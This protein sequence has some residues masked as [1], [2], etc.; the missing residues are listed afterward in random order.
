MDRL[1]HHLHDAEDDYLASKPKIHLGKYKNC[2]NSV[3]FLAILRCIRCSTYR[4]P[5]TARLAREHFRRTRADYAVQRIFY[6]KTYAAFCLTHF[7]LDYNLLTYICCALCEDQAAG[8]ATC[9]SIGANMPEI[10]CR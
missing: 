9:T 1:L 3:M 10:F 5:K 8:M 4:Y 6:N 7:R 2:N